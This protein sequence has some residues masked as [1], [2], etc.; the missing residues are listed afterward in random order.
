MIIHHRCLSILFIYPDIWFILRFRIFYYILSYYIIYF[1]AIAIALAIV[2][3][4]P[5]AIA[6]VG[7]GEKTVMVNVAVAVAFEV[8]EMLFSWVLTNTWR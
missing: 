7:L 6:V 8:E 4:I 1:L 3:A 5:N 2:L